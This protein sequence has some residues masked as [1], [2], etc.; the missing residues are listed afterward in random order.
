M[1]LIIISID[2]DQKAGLVERKFARD[3]LPGVENRLFLEIV[4]ERE[5][6][7]HLE[8][9]VVARRVTD[10]V[11]VIVL[12]ASAHAFLGGCGA[13]IG[14]RLCA[15]ENVLERHHAGID[16]QQGRIVLRNQRRRGRDGV[17]PT[18]KIVEEGGAD[19]VQARHGR[20]R[21]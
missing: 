20:S 10:I 8:K 16:E 17:T 19:F 5:V 2:G 3:Q 9:S 1:G 14:P 4:A 7:Q 6:A 15:G 18:L 21:L 11:E 12:A 13:G